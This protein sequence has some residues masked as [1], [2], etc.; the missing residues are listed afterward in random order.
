[1]KFFLMMPLVFLL[2]ACFDNKANN[3]TSVI[4]VKAPYAFATVP[5]AATGAAFMVIQGGNEDDRL[6]AAQS[7]I[8]EITEIHE[9]LIDPD[10]GMMMMRKI[11]G[12]DIPAKADVVLKPTGY[13]VMFIKLKEPLTMGLKVPFTLTF[14]KAG[15]VEV[16]ATIIAPGAKFKETP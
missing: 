9:N 2:S 8:A 13:H 14:E 4:Q 6:I 3:E 10:D 1:M 5:G 12:L 15:N 7:D 11:R 16:R